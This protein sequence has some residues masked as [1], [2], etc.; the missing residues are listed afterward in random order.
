[1]SS[2]FLLDEISLATLTFKIQQA[3]SEV[4]PITGVILP[5]TADLTL[6]VFL[7]PKSGAKEIEH[8]GV[9][10]SSVY[11]EGYLVNPMIMPKTVLPGAIA[12]Y[13]YTD[14]FNVTH[15]GEFIL[16]SSPPSVFSVVRDELGDKIVGYLNY[17]A[18]TG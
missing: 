6:S 11:M 12:Q 7:R 1:M 3:G 13:T 4:D 15:T 5:T 8:P 2:P 18:K 17:T 16:L 10:S 9:N 14:G